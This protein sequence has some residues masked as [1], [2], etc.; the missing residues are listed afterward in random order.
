MK[1]GTGSDINLLKTYNK[2]LDYSKSFKKPNNFGTTAFQIVHYA[3]VVEYEIN[4]FLEKNN[5]TVSD[6]VNDTL[7]KS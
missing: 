4:G 6:I 3:G 1:K 2:M 7:M 5:D